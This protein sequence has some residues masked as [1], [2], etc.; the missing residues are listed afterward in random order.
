MMNSKHPELHLMP[1]QPA[2]ACKHSSC[3]DVFS[4]SRIYGV[5]RACEIQTWRQKL[6]FFFFFS[7]GLSS[8]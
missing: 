1:F 6:L 8:L 3:T 5:F 4:P 2:R 7:F